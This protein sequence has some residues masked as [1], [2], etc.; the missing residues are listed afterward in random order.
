ML[1]WKGEWGQRRR[2]ADPTGMLGSRQEGLLGAGGQSCRGARLPSPSG[3]HCTVLPLPGA[4]E[5][6]TGREER[7]EAAHELGDVAKLLMPTEF[8]ICKTRTLVALQGCPS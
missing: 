5:G 1:T 7:T 8:L 4:F 6:T 2:P 3:T